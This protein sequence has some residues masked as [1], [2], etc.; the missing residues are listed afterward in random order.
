LGILPTEV[1]GN[2][3]LKIHLVM[4][5]IPHNNLISQDTTVRE[6]CFLKQLSHK[7]ERDV[8]PNRCSSLNI[9]IQEV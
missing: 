2:H 1:T 4:Y 9:E 5:S 3:T 7:L 6:G 8:Y